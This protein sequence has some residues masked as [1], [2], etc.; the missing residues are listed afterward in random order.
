MSEIRSHVVFSSKQAW[1]VL[2][3]APRWNKK[4]V[5][6]FIQGEKGPA[7]SIPGTVVQ[8]ITWSKSIIW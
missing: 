4:I 1:G 2:F 3:P 6:D 7:N 5:G 8:E